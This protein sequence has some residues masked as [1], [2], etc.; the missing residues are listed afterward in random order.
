MKQADYI[1]GKV[2]EFVTWMSERLDDDTFKHAYTSRRTGA[3]WSCE[4]LFD[5]YERYLWAYGD[6]S[7]YGI[8]SGNSFASSLHALETLQ[9][10]LTAGLAVGDNERVHRAA[11]GVVIWGGVTNGNRKW[12]NDNRNKLCHIIGRTRD[13]LNAGDTEDPLFAEKDLRFTSGMSKVYSLVCDDFVIYDSR[14]AAALG[15]AIVQF[16][17]ERGLTEVPGGLN[18]AWAPAKSTPGAE[19]PPQ[20]NAGQDRL[21]FPRLTSGRI[22]AEWNMLASWLLTAIVD[23][24]CTRKSAF[25]TRIESR[26]QRLRAL[27]AALFMIGY[28]LGGGSN[29]SSNPHPTTRPGRPRRQADDGQ[30]AA[31]AG[32]WVDCETRAQGNP[33]EY[34]LGLDAIHTRRPGGKSVIRFPHSEI[35]ETLRR[36]ASHFGTEPFPLANSADGVRQRTVSFGLGTAYFVATGQ[37]PPNTSRLAA[38]LEDI[39]VFEPVVLNGKRWKLR[40]SPPFQYKGDDSDC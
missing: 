34:R 10:E 9:K 31:E 25:G 27:E 12:L 7:G 35:D 40:N 30:A 26:T 5:A 19:N 39:G 8:P 18:F 22:Y 23:H 21:T 37:N 29:M 6:L 4:S 36:L 28:D 16:C 3:R 11:I 24:E 2:G 38:V 33:F 14:V 15:R 17:V 20:R 32:E 1:T 13:V